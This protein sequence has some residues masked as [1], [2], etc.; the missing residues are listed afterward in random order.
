MSDH[1]PPE[2]IV[3]AGLVIVGA[4]LLGLAIGIGWGGFWLLSEVLR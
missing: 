4:V 3:I 1:T 2:W